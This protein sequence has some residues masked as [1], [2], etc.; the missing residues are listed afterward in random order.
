[1][2]AMSTRLKRHNYACDK[3]MMF[4]CVERRKSYAEILKELG[5]FIECARFE[6]A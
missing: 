6:Q 1:M 4:S 5:C 2:E 3:Q